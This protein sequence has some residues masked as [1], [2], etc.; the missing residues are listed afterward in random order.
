[1]D[2]ISFVLGVQSRDLRSSTLKELIHRPPNALKEGAPKL[3]ASA[4]L[5][6]RHERTSTLRYSTKSNTKKRSKKG[7]SSSSKK[8]RS[9]RHRDDHDH[10]SASEDDESEV[11]EKGDE[12]SSADSDLDPDDNDDNVVSTDDEP[13]DEEDFEFTR[14]ISPNGVS[15]YRINGSTC[16]F[17]EYEATLKRIGVLLK[18]RHNF[19]IFQGDV[20]AIAR[21]SPRDLVRMLEDISGSG[22]LSEEY[23]RLQK[24]LS[25]A[26][27]AVNHASGKTRGMKSERKM[28]K[29]QKEEAERYNRIR[30]DKASTLTEYFLW[31]LYH[32][33]SEITE[34]EVHVAEVRTEL[35]EFAQQEKVAQESLRVCKKKV[36]AARRAVNTTDKTR[37][38]LVAQ[39]DACNPHKIK[40]SEE[41]KD[42]MV[43]L[44]ADREA[45]KVIQSESQGHSTHLEELQQEYTECESQEKALEEEYETTKKQC[46]NK[47]N[48]S[49]T[50]Q[51]QIVLTAEQE[52]R[53]ETLQKEAAVASAKQRTQLARHTRELES[54][55]AKAARLHEECKEVTLR[56]NEAKQEVQELHQRLNQRKTVLGSTTTDLTKAEKLLNTVLTKQRHAEQR[57]GEIDE[58]LSRINAQLREA[59]DDRKQ[60][61][62]EERLLQA[63]ASLKR[64]FQGVHGRLVDLCRPTQRRYN[65][66]VTVAGGKDLDAIVVQDKATAYEC[67]RY[68][69]EQ[70]VGIATFLP[71]DS[72]KIPSN[73]ERIRAICEADASHRYRLASD[74]IQCD[75]A[76]LVKAIHYAVGNTVVCD[77]LECA[78]AL[79]FDSNR[80]RGEKI[81][82]VTLSGAIISKAGTMTGGLT[83]ETS[84][85]TNKWDVQFIE[86]LRT[87]KEELELER[88]NLDSYEDEDGIRTSYKVKSDEVRNMVETLRNRQQFTQSDQVYNETQLKQAES[89]HR[90]SSAQLKNLKKEIDS[91][92]ASIQKVDGIIKEIR[93]NIRKVED[94]ILFDF[95]EETGL[96]D[97]RS[98]DAAVAVARAGKFIIDQIVDI[99]L[100]P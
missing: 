3:K 26:E 35:Q 82:A 16:T 84:S 74:V 49:G 34:K 81:K 78:R 33:H 56:Q 72:L 55:R 88:E 51:Q 57:H 27:L 99:V 7:T 100:Y 50:N 62:K 86:Q 98:Y 90:S 83:A 76:S 53:Y 30:S 36:S 37:V 75:D 12:A 40:Y 2:A 19:L 66:A 22:A 70:R 63:L 67:I 15:E 46:L 8:R 77:D 73:T 21:K 48:S 85:N 94:E 71:L 23:I 44:E 58:Q 59:R 41:R 13:E 79:C 52:S 89:L 4:T 29:E 61:K 31:Q 38:G 47:H 20:E 1:M 64:H 91:T 14:T 93:E 43:K 60:N 95:R 92:E 80:N 32:L 10:E 9:S 65:L 96:V 11:E 24:E 68:L 28:L 54:A 45:L 42:L 25:E 69:R 6:Y 17:T 5:R 87:Q 18:A 39:V 97:L